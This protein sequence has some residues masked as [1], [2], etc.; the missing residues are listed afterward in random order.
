M[1]FVQKLKNG[2][3][4]AAMTAVI[5]GAVSIVFLDGFKSTSVLGTPLPKFLVSG[6]AL[7]VSSFGADLMVPYVTPLLSKMGMP[8]GMQNL[9]NVLLVPV[10][11]GASVL[12]FEM[13]VAPEIVA[14]SGGTMSALLAGSGSS[15]AAYYLLDSLHIISN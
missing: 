13:I 12:A 4:K 10:L 7:G 1:S 9:E 6:A 15:I 8:A 5:G 3:R 14:Q 2:S 11:A